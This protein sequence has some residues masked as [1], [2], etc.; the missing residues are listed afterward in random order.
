MSKEFITVDGVHVEIDK[1]KNL[2]ELVRKAGVDLPT[3]CYHS[4]L[5]VFG[6]CRMCVCEVE[7]RGLMAT[8]STPPQAGM[9]LKTNTDATMRIRRMALELL[10]S[11]HC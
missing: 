11:N 6:A 1:E 8:C 4:E 2:L 5:S 9:V 3:F 10:L 7:G